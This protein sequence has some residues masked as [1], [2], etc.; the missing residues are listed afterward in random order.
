MV[1]ICASGAIIQKHKVFDIVGRAITNFKD[2]RVIAL[3]NTDSIVI[4]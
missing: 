2:L 4:I 1:G 3:T